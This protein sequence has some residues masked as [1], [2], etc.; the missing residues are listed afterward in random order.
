MLEEYNCA[1]CFFWDAPSTEEENLSKL[2]KNLQR[3][4]LDKTGTG[5][6]D[7]LSKQEAINIITLANSE[8]DIQEPN[9]DCIKQ[10]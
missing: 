5:K 10:P 2:E 9:Y 7:I 4:V 1:Q 6:I 8:H 3:T